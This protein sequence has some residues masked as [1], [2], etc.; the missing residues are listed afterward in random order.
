VIKIERMTEAHFK[1]AY[2]IELESFVIPWAREDFEKDVSANKLSYYL[3]ALDEGVTVGYA[4]MWRVFDE[5]HI[6]NVA[7]ASAAR[8]R[9]VGSLLI[10]SLIKAAREMDMIGLTLEVRVGNERAQRLYAKFGFKPEG[11]RKNYYSDTKE[12]A[13]IMWKYFSDC[14]PSYDQYEKKPKK[15]MKK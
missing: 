4:G 11:L 12:D 15:G 1:E 8:R 6:T 3:V 13:I 2:K 10:S 7:V 14:R 9:G 5:A